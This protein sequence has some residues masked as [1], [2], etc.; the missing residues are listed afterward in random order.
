VVDVTLSAV[1]RDVSV[2]GGILAGAV[3]F[4]IFLFMVPFVFVLVA[5]F[6]LAADAADR[7]A[8]DLAEDAGAAG[9]I[10][11]SI[12]SVAQESLG[13]RLAVFLVGGLASVLAARTFLKV[14]VAAH[15]RVWGVP[16]AR[17]RRQVRATVGVVLTVVLGLAMVQ[18][19]S[20]LRDRSPAAGI[21]GTALFIA[22]PAGVWLLASLTI[23]PS[24]EGA[25]WRDLVAGALFVGVGI[26]AL[27]LFTVVWIVRS[28]E[29]KTEA[30][31]A[32][33][34]SLALLLWA[35]VLGRI[36]TGAAVLNATLWSRH[37]PSDA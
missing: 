7:P 8:R 17:V 19:L 10:A 21:M 32:V 30:Y 3:A 12:D 37:H 31:G 33:G 26:Q 18:A 34:T 9:L 29:H 35:Y 25:G 6:G 23:F 13:T 1:E 16:P 11:S 2:G 15:V 20:Y 5:G 36:L 24:A 27:H 14:L 22:V 4:R 28:L